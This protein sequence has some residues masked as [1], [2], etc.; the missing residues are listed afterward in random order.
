MFCLYLP[1]RKA[2]L[3]L[4]NLHLQFQICTCAKTKECLLAF[5]LS[6]AWPLGFNIFNKVSFDDSTASEREQWM[7]F[8]TRPD[9]IENQMRRLNP[10]PWTSFHLLLLPFI[11]F[12]NPWRNTIVFI[13]RSRLLFPLRRSAWPRRPGCLHFLSQR[14]QASQFSWL[15]LPLTSNPVPPMHPVPSSKGRKSDCSQIP[16]GL[17]SVWGQNPQSPTRIWLTVLFL[18]LLPH[19]RECPFP[20]TISEW[21][22]LGHPQTGSPGVAVTGTV[23]CGATKRVSSVSEVLFMGH[24]L[25]WFFSSVISSHL[26]AQKAPSWQVCGCHSTNQPAHQLVTIISA[27]PGCAHPA[28]LLRSQP[29]SGI[30]LDSFIQ[31]SDRAV[32][33]GWSGLNTDAGLSGTPSRCLIASPRPPSQ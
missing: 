20:N 5:K 19:S 3:S 18:G 2:S 4:K 12:K 1:A 23:P 32:G 10:E 22:A 9:L 27:A 17:D 16:P 8:H 30:S 6:L 29:N 28:L 11:N 31:H 15:P 14:H 7:S 33:T 21:S 13:S 24:S 26:W 25:P